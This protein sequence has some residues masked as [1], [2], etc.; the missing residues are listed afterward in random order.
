VA[1]APDLLAALK[2]IV[3]TPAYVY[4]Y[5][6]GERL[7]AIMGMANEAIRKADQNWDKEGK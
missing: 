2:K 6:D 3:S 5:H 4:D 7:D 1:A